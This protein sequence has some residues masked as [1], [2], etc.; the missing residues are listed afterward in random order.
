MTYMLIFIDFKLHFTADS[1]TFICFDCMIG[2]SRTLQN[3][4]DINQFKWS[5]YDYASNG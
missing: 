5:H 4:V 3:A 1:S 2:K